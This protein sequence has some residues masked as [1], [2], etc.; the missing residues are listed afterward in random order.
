MTAGA[1]AGPDGSPFEESRI[2]AGV[3]L[4][5]H[6][7]TRRQRQGECGQ[8]D[9]SGES[10]APRRSASGAN[11]Q[12]ARETEHGTDGSDGANLVRHPILVFVGF[13]PRRQHKRT[14]FDYAF[15]AASFV[16]VFILLAWALLG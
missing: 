13:D 7:T 2:S 5:S 8:A 10:R 12:G 14:P 11:E 9:A 4:G 3:D 15:V 16:A 6:A 1:L